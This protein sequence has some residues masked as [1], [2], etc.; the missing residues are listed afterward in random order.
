MRDYYHADYP[1]HLHTTAL[2]CW[3]RDMEQAAIIL[4]S[5]F[6]SQSTEYRLV[7]DDITHNSC[8]YSTVM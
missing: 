8:K 5:H 1:H 3:C 2:H 7:G 6:P 4:N